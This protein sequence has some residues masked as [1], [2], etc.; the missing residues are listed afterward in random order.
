MSITL[1]LPNRHGNFIATVLP[2]YIEK[3]LFRRIKDKDVPRMIE[4]GSYRYR[5]YG[6]NP[7]RP[8]YGVDADIQKLNK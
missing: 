8:A 2:K 6:Y 4:I 7:Q 1:Y 3:I 5:I